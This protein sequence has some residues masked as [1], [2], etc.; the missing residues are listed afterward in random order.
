MRSWRSIH[1]DRLPPPTIH[2]S[3]PTQPLSCVHG[4]GSQNDHQNDQCCRFDAE[5]V[6]SGQGV[7]SEVMGGLGELGSVEVSSTATCLSNRPLIIHPG[8][9]THP[10]IQWIT[11][12]SSDT[13]LIV[14][15]PSETCPTNQPLKPFKSFTS[16]KSSFPSVLKNY[17]FLYSSPM[18]ALSQTQRKQQK[19][20]W[21]SGSACVLIPHKTRGS[22]PGQSK[23]TKCTYAHTRKRAY[24]FV[25][26][27][28]K[29]KKKAKAQGIEP[30]YT[31]KVHICSV[32][33][34]S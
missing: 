31:Y 14:D 27:N 12:S 15:P 10:P 23:C 30:R 20:W 34:I 17:F 9:L 3:S 24:L 7:E 32:V 13:S 18:T 4:W 2:P 16:F 28:N 19:L 26:L 33:R 8:T 5:K 6:C 22:I 1:H 29:F 25:N 21:H 11:D